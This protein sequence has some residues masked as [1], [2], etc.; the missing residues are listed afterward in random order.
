MPANRLLKLE[1][2]IGTW[3]T[4]GTV[5]KTSVNPK[6]TLIATDTY[7]WLP[8]KRFIVHEVD[9]RFDG[10]PSR[11]MEVMGWNARRIRWF[12]TSYDDQGATES[13]ELDLTGRRWRIRGKT[14]RF[15]GSFD[16]AR[17]RL[18]GLWELKARA[19]WEPW[20]ELLLR[21]DSVPGS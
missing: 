3:N 12:S 8:G 4:T 18:E 20:I 16:P 10:S 13:F 9:A 7:R 21:R 1:V 19:R 2:F 6:G 5:L 17:N 15:D 11:S 14:V